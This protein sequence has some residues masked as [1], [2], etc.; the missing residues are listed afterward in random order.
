MKNNG[1]IIIYDNGR[2]TRNY[3]R[4][5]ELNPKNNSIEWIYKKEPA[6]DFYSSIMGSAQPLPNNNILITEA[7]QGRAFEIND[8]GKVLWEYDS[9][10]KGNRSENGIYRMQRV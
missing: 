10:F 7:T 2:N 5:I 6:E 9:S 3:S 1:N 8:K 4:V